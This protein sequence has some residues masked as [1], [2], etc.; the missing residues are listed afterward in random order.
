M[1]RQPR[2]SPR[3][4]PDVKGPL[5][6]SAV[7][8]LVAGGVTSFVAAGGTDDGLRLDLGLIVGG[9]AFIASVV[10]SATLMMLDK[11]ND[12]HLGEGS[13]VNRSSAKLYAERR[14]KRRAAETSDAS[15][16]SATA[17]PQTGGPAEDANGDPQYGRRVHPE[18]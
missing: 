2:K 11:P 15:Q 8:A 1:S 6:V 17:K 18:Q 9:V 13:G 4:A 12:P 10:V 3:R 16:G 5:V 7:L 14:A